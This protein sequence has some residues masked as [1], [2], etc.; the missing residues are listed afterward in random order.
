MARPAA[1][2]AVLVQSGVQRATGIVPTLLAKRQRSPRAL[3]SFLC[4]FQR[5][6]CSPGSA[7]CR[8]VP[9]RCGQ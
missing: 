2:K 8:R 6:C 5:A 1:C 3:A 7:R 4:S 9:R